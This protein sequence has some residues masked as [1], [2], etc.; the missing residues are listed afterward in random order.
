[1]CTLFISVTLVPSV[2]YS[3]STFSLWPRKQTREEADAIDGRRILSKASSIFGKKQDITHLQPTLCNLGNL[4]KLWLRCT[5]VKLVWKSWCC[6]Y[7]PSP[8]S[9]MYVDTSACPHCASPNSNRWRRTNQQ[10]HMQPAAD[11]SPDALGPTSAAATT[12]AASEDP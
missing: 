11:E 12:S 9:S 1:M 2:A 8:Y 10:T 5:R 7:F 6:V 4:D 3:F